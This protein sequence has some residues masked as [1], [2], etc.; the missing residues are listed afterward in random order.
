[1]SKTSENLKT[2]FAGESQAYQ[3]YKAFAKKASAEGF[4][5]IAKLFETTAEAE[6]VHAEGHLKALDGIKDTLANLQEAISGETYEYEEMYPPMLDEAKESGH[7]ASRMFGYAPAAEEVHARI[8]ELALEA[9]K[10]GKD[11]EI[12]EFFLCPVCGYIELGKKPDRCPICNAIGDK[13]VLL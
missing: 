8:Y 9:V 4:T 13:F 1:M 10:Q 3:K 6:L 5:N 7:K 12:T 2:A 11:L